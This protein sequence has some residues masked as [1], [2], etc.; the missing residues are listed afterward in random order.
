M[1]PK[2]NDFYIVFS[3]IFMSFPNLLLEAIFGRSKRR[4]MNKSAILEPF[5]IQGGAKNTPLGR[6]YLDEY[7]GMLE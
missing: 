1:E 2:N 5:W 6:P 4:S 7:L 3:F